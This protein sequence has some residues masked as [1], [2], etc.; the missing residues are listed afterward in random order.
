MSAHFKDVVFSAGG[1]NYTFRWG[2]NAT[3][4]LE[5]KCGEPAPKFFQR[6]FKDG[7]IN[8][9]RLVM[10]CGLSRHH[11]NLTLEQVGDLIDEL[12]GADGVTEIF[13]R[14][15]EREDANKSANPP[16]RKAS[17]TGKKR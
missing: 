10:F 14:A 17:G 8:D 5:Q 2:T 1:E 13:G 7:S 15:F 11:K 16:N 9:L 3:A 4:L 12:G 6:S